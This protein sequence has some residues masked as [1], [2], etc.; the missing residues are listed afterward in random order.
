MPVLSIH[1]YKNTPYR[2]SRM[3][4]LYGAIASLQCTCSLLQL[5]LSPYLYNCPGLMP[6]SAPWPLTALVVTPPLHQCPE[7]CHA[8]A[9][10]SSKTCF[11]LRL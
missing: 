3:Q 10:K 6:L 7:L 9:K 11:D 5:A 8:L 1:K 2:Y 4:Y